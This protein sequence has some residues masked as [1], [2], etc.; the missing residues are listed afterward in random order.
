MIEILLLVV[1]I[2]LL[3][4][5]FD[6]RL[7]VRRY[8]VAAPG[9]CRPVR[10]V[11]L[12]D[13]HSTSHGDK[14]ARLLRKIEACEPDF[15]LIAGDMVDKKRPTQETEYLYQG[16]G[17][18]PSYYTIGNH[19]RSRAD[20][21]A[22]KAKAIECGVTVLTNETVT[23]DSEAGPLFISG[24][25][26]PSHTKQYAPDFDHKKVAAELSEAAAERSGYQILISHRPELIGRYT[27]FD[28][29]V[30]GHT[31]GG[32]LRIPGLL[33]GLVSPGQGFFPKQA[34]GVYQHGDTTLVIS[35]GLSRHWLRPRVFTRP[36]VVVIELTPG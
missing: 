2:V 11:L 33:N 32:L 5:A 25:D 1:G 6:L 7:I 31:H 30:S 15:V 36:E 12:T 16:L 10:I 9:L 13:L 14:Q 29:V 26:D 34:G 18:Y 3:A 20:L 27:G 19:E 17:A 35:R 23:V 8:Q 22:V 21:E 28:L 4:F 24:I